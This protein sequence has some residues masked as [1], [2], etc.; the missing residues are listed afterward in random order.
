MKTWQ[1]VL[2]GLGVAGAAVII[3]RKASGTPVESLSG[4]VLSQKPTS[5]PPD[6][7]ETGYRA[8][9]TDVN[10]AILDP[11]HVVKSGAQHW[12]NWGWSEGRRWK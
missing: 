3:A 5:L 6:F 8:I 7:D 10:S 1:K 12:L 9:N 2:I 4:K 11:N